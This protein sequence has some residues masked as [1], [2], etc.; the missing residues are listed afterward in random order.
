MSDTRTGDTNPYGAVTTLR[1]TIKGVAFTTHA[2]SAGFAFDT[3]P[4]LLRIASG[5]AGLTVDLL[6]SAMLGGSIAHANISGEEV[7]AGLCALAQEAVD[8]GGSAFLKE[9]LGNTVME[10]QGGQ[11]AAKLD[12]AFDTVFQRRL[13]LAV[14]VLA[15][16]LEVNLV[17]FEGGAQRPQLLGSLTTWLQKWQ[18]ASPASPPEATSPPS[19]TSGSES[20]ES[21]EPPPA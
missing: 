20:Q 12:L 15:W 18:A 9:L 10:A 14:E 2:W 4:K 6:R 17:P 8:V 19:D 13:G 11:P 1:K 16:V 21:G 7:R 3:L 5:P